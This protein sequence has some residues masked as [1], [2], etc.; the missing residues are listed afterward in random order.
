MRL[1]ADPQFI[2]SRGLNDFTTAYVVAFGCQV[3]NQQ[4]NQPY[5]H[6]IIFVDFYKERDKSHEFKSFIRHSCFENY[7]W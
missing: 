5:A 4:I 7:F 3:A 1:A 2:K 6:P